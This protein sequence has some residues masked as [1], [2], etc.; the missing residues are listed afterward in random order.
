MEIFLSD[1]ERLLID[2]A[3]IASITSSILPSGSS[4][5]TRNC[6]R[7]LRTRT[8]RPRSARYSSISARCSGLW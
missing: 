6:D 1:L 3:Q 8:S 5:L 4:Q 7:S 2:R